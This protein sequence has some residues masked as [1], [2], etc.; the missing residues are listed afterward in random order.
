MAIEGCILSIID[1]MLQLMGV[2]KK[3]LINIVNLTKIVGIASF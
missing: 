1:F 3:K 2:N